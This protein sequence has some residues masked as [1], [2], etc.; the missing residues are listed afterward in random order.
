MPIRSL[1]PIR[2]KSL[3][4]S[5]LETSQQLQSRMPNIKGNYINVFCCSSRMNFQFFF[6]N[7]LYFFSLNL[8]I[9]LNF[10]F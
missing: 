5:N 8:N 1:N 4:R 7:Y 9:F 6:V 10:S 2:A 3:V